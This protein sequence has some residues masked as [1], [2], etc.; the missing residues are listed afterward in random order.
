M[1]GG[2]GAAG[3]ETLREA[4]VTSGHEHPDLARLAERTPSRA[5]DTVSR[6]LDPLVLVTAVSVLVSVASSPHW[7]AGVG[8][9]ALV[10]TFCAG[11]PEI[12]LRLLVR[13]GRAADRQ[14][15]RRESRAVP[16][17]VAL[18]SVVVGVVALGLL[19][20]PRP[21]VALVVTIFVGLL[22]IGAITRF[23]KASFHADV[24]ATVA[25]VLAVMFG[26][27]TALVSVPLVAL[28]SWA[29]VRSGRHSLAQVIVGLALGVAV[30]GVVF[31]LVAG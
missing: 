4:A 5:A 29:R 18:G 1:T 23:W 15:V 27:A 14:L 22:V 28:V 8:W 24:A 6:V 25:V 2:V 17:L 30:T 9:A 3:D 19:G 11:I 20:A 31:P 13:S 21:L 12:T 10:V 16:V 7:W 26:P